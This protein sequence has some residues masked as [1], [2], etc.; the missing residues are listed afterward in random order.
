MINKPIS[1]FERDI[2]LI[3]TGCSK[4]T[5]FWGRHL[6]CCIAGIQSMFWG[7]LA[8]LDTC[9][10]SF[11]YKTGHRMR[12]SLREHVTTVQRAFIFPIHR[13]L[14]TVSHKIPQSA[15]FISTITY[16]LALELQRCGTLQLLLRITMTNETF[17][18][19]Q[20]CFKR[21]FHI[22]IDWPALL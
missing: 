2:I 4:P 17:A 7:S 15:P 14:W 9:V 11:F 6:F 10:S 5:P 1:I 20:M 21:D 22:I 12:D 3:W 8:N 13:G 18:S 19:L 16:Q